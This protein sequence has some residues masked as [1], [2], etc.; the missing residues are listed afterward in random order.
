MRN[1][2]R[3]A[4]ALLITLWA[5]SPAHGQEM[6][7]RPYLLYGGN[8]QEMMI[9]WQVD[10][11]ES[12][13]IEWGTDGTYA[14]G[15]A[16]TIELG[17]DHQH[18]YVIRGLTPGKKYFYRV[19]EPDTGAYEGDFKAA[20]AVATTSRVG[21][22]A[23]G[24]THSFYGN[25]FA[26][27]RVC[28]RVVE[29]YS[30]DPAFQTMI[31]HS[32]DWTSYDSDVAWDL[33]FFGSYASHARTLTSQ[34]ATVGCR[35]NH[36]AAGVWFRSYWPFPYVADFYWSFDYGPVH[37]AVVDEYVPFDPGSEQ[38]AWLEDDLANSP[39][40]FKIL[41]LHEPGWAA[42]GSHPNHAGVQ[43]YLQP[44]CERYGVTMVFAA[45]NHNYARAVVN[46]VQH[47]TTGGGGGPL[48]QCYPSMPNVVTCATVHH[49]TKFMVRDETLSFWAIDENGSILDSFF[50]FS[51]HDLD[52]R[53]Q[54]ATSD[55]C[56]LGGA[57][58]QNG[59]VEPGETAIL[60]VTLAND[61]WESLTEV[62]AVLSSITPG[63][64]FAPGRDASTYPDLAPRQSSGGDSDFEFHVDPGQVGC[65]AVLEF[66]LAMTYMTSLGV[67]TE[68][69]TIPLAIP[70]P[71]IPCQQAC[72]Q[73]APKR[74]WPML[75]VREGSD[76]EFFWTPDPRAEGGYNLYSSDSK[77]DI[78]NLRL[79]NPP[80]IPDPI[81]SVP[82]SS[83]SSVIL[84]DGIAQGLLFYQILGICM[85]GET[86]GPN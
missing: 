3:H 48:C 68:V 11:E 34:I 72:P 10:A 84:P 33:E 86:E 19:T 17:P 83:T 50:T 30:F 21:F 43:D 57:G 35:G 78:P 26:F 59:V 20:P 56:S 24:D 18:E 76:M 82:D 32:G 85:D 66:Q 45:H 44:L 23:F 52:R 49:Y 46:G 14:S 5:L 31:L 81:L 38:Y 47:I 4:M 69:G 22:F 53:S 27:E 70:D 36:E 25:R 16:E 65:G 15:S 8:N 62:R 7:K 40:R 58:D 63:V 71:C 55:T 12:C 13:T 80:P 39:N 28:T 77:T 1:R 6:P 29:K 67:R 61:G 74:V 79:E 54:T 42:L 37:V 2:G 51:K 60:S 64:S 75:A 73:G 41:I 9:R